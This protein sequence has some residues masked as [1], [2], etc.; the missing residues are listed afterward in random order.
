MRLNNNT[1]AFFA[2]IRAGLWRDTVADE[3][4][5]KGHDFSVVDWQ[6]VYEL[7]DEQLVSG[8]LLAAIE[9]LPRN[10]RPP[11]PLLMQWIGDIQ[12]IE[13]QNQSL[14]E[15]VAWLIDRLR[16][17]DINAVL[18]KGQG[19]AQCYA[20]PI[21][22]APGDVDLLLSDADYEKA[23][24]VLIPLAESVDKEFTLY[25]HIGMT[26]PGELLVELH[27]TLHSR[28]SHRVD[29][30][31][32]EAQ[33]DVFSGGCVRSWINGN[34]QVFLP[35]PD[36][37]VIF[38]FTHILKHFYQGGIGI[39]QICDLCRFL[40]TYQDQLDTPLL[41]KRIRDMHLMSEWQ[42]FTA[43]AVDFFGMPESAFPLYSPCKKWSRK[44]KV[45]NNF[46]LEAGDFGHNRDNGNTGDYPYLI[47]K[48]IAFWCRTKDSFRHF[49]I[50]PV[51]SIK[52]WWTVLVTGVKEL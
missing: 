41:E 7:A 45:I 18:V 11:K 6:K 2:L 17:E 1:Q 5:L 52:A 16:E 21:W 15:Y 20:K 44:A 4:W 19:I 39:R 48:A 27:G 35:G 22:R 33:S 42:A 49:F 12:M 24:K 26:M 43:Y 50:F 46:V 3:S 30:I 34:T 47:N 51:N 8:L 37:D 40:W 14:N 10:Q 31:I 28:L 23:K 32:D 13:Q 9:V 36:S 25:K 29:R 38:L